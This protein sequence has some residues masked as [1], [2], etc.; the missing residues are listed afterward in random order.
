MITGLCSELHTFHLASHM[1]GRLRFI[2]FYRS[3]FMG[4]TSYIVREIR[5][6]VARMQEI[7]N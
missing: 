2:G 5:E 6:R 1:V 4:Y 7:E 3:D